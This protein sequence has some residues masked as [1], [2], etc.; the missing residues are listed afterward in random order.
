T[1]RHVLRPIALLGEGAERIRAGNFSVPVQVA[2]H[3]ELAGLA[4]SFN[5]MSQNLVRSMDEL[6]ESQEKLRQAEKIQ[7]TGELVGGVAHAFN[8]RLPAIMAES[9]L[10]ESQLPA[11]TGR[12]RAAR[13]RDAAQHAAIL[14]RQLLAF[15]RKQQLQPQV[16]GLNE[17]VS[18]IVDR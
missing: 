10:L 12:D 11:G 17:L 1:R 15:G 9:E 6:C 7:A 18:G 2:T 8:N 3:D 13:I 14:T 5:D 16:L 4:R